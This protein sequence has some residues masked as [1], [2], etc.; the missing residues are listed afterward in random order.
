V[1][2]LRTHDPV[3]RRGEGSELRARSNTVVVEG[4]ASVVTRVWGGRG[5]ILMEPARAVEVQTG[6]GEEQ[7][8]AREVMGRL[9]VL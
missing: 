7:G 3:R 9:T 2:H 8:E 4:G 6:F 5:Y 1:Q